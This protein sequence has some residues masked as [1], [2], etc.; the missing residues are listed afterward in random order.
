MTTQDKSIVGKK[1][2]ILPKKPLRE[3]SGIKA[4]D[5]I[6]IEAYPG[7]LIVK[8]IYSVE[9]LLEMPIIAQGTVEEIERE[10]EEEGKQQEKMT[11]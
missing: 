4:G 6:L 5:E 9:D 11:D 7:K 1:G 2:E 8:K 3:I 10:I